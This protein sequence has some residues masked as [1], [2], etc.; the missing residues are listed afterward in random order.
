MLSVETNYYGS[1]WPETNRLPIFLQQKKRFT[2]DKPRIA[3]QGLQLR[4]ATL[5][6]LCKKWKGELFYRGEKEV[7]RAIVNRIYGFSLADLWQCL[8]GWVLARKEEDVFL[9]P[10]GLFTG[11]RAWD[12][13]LLVSQ[14]YLIE[15]S[16]Y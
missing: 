7:G 2:W 3:V 10:V 8:I 4:Q 1:F 15:A 16:V 12:L 6:L 5:Q 9:L 14:L 11:F 13:P